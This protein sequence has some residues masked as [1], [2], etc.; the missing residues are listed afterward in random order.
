MGQTQARQNGIG[1][2][3]QT[4]GA[5]VREGGEYHP[6]VFCILKKAGH[7]PWECA[8]EFVRDLGPF[9]DRDQPPLVAEIN[10]ARSEQ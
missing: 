1:Q 2:T 9:I 5:W 8:R 3:C 10:A 6:Y 4:C 7:D